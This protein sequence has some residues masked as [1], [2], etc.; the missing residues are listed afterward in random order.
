MWQYQPWPR[1]QTFV[2]ALLEA[3]K[4]S[5]VDV[6]W[7]HQRWGKYQRL[8]KLRARIDVG[9]YQR[10][11]HVKRARGTHQRRALQNMAQ[12]DSS[13]SSSSSESGWKRCALA[14]FSTKC[15]NGFPPFDYID[16][17]WFRSDS[18]IDD[19][20]IKLCSGPP[21]IYDFCTLL[22]PATISR[23]IISFL[24]PHARRIIGEQSIRRIISHN[25]IHTPHMFP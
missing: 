11:L 18:K 1:S 22:G 2:A 15:S 24:I 8:L 19:T 3:R 25:T 13:T 21:A 5:R 23:D 20:Y 6:K 7:K 14:T 16:S 10:A 12:S 9:K 4:M 17:L